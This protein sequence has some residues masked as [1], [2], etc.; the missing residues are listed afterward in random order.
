MKEESVPGL[1]PWI[2]D[3]GLLP[4]S[5]HHLPSIHVCVQMFSSYKYTSDFALR[6]TLMTSLQLNHNNKG[7]ISKHSQSLKYWRLGLQHMNLRG[8]GTE[9]DTQFNP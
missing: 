8:V 5:S 9:D 6:P 4:M 1:H 2:I 3:G 7:S